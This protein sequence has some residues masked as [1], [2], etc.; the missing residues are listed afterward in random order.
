MEKRLHFLSVGH[1]CHDKIDDT[2]ILGGTASY[3]SLVAH[4]LNY[5]SSV[6]TSFGP[7]FKFRQ[8]FVNEG[9]HLQVVPHT[10][11]TIFENI[12]TATGRIQFLHQRAAEISKQYIQDIPQQ[13]DIILLCP[14]ANEVNIDVIDLFPDALKGASIQGW[15]RHREADGRIV[16][17]EMDWSKLSKLDIVIISE[18]DIGYSK[19]KLNN[20]I[21]AVSHVVLTDGMNGAKVFLDG[22]EYHF[23]AFPV[24]EVEATGAGDVF[25]IAYLHEY[26][27]TK[28]VQK[29]CI[30]AHCAASFI[31]EGIGVK[32]LPTN[33]KIA[34]R[35][36]VYSEKS[37]LTLNDLSSQ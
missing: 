6:I 29:A 24:K 23:P 4:Q 18:E 7:D 25:T 16:P 26:F 22:S 30:F 28:N 31:V 32:N 21:N 2:Y 20:I 35:V 19:D 33:N 3:A 34:E 12:Y 13:A 36:S 37:D 8:E 1:C 15:L 27:A 9:I 10:L 11:T 17:Q 5:Q 14:I